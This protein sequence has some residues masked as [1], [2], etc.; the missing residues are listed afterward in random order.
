[1]C[2]AFSS[3]A[4]EPWVAGTD[5]SKHGV[6]A[7]QHKVRFGRSSQPHS[8]CGGCQTFA[9]GR[10]RAVDRN[11]VEDAA[12]GGLIQKGPA[13]LQLWLSRVPEVGSSP[14]ARHGCVGAARQAPPDGRAAWNGKAR[15][16]RGR[17]SGRQGR[18][19]AG[20]HIGFVIGAQAHPPQYFGGEDHFIDGTRQE[21][22]LRWLNAPKM[23]PVFR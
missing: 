1:M 9:T 17:G 8:R 4:R 21:L 22:D 20:T 23:A 16:S 15:R 7:G 5:R 19:A 11:P 18:E 2:G 3:C 12:T 14:T 6:P 13:R 10:T